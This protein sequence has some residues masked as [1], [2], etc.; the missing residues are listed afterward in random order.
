MTLVR[1]EVTEICTVAATPLKAPDPNDPDRLVGSAYI[2]ADLGNISPMTFWR[3]EHAPNPE[4][5]LPP[6]DIIIGSSKQKRWRLGT[7]KMWKARMLKRGHVRLWR[8][9]SKAEGDAA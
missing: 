9:G 4:E 7:Y 3:W 5:R 8:Q 2:K 6:P 1:N